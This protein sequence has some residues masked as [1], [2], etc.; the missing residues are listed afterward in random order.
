MIKPI[1]HITANIFCNTAQSKID[2]F[3]IRRTKRPII[4]YWEDGDKALTFD[5][6]KNSLP[7]VLVMEKV[8][9]E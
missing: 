7:D 5:K 3:L 4:V 9:F 2:Q 6:I 1:D 8:F